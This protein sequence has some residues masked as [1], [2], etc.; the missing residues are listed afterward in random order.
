MLLYSYCFIQLWAGRDCLQS[1]SNQEGILKYEFVTRLIVAEPRLS[2]ENILRGEGAP[3][4]MK[5]SPLLR[6]QLSNYGSL[7]PR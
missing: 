2:A 5:N 6:Q 3:L 4:W 7:R 1:D